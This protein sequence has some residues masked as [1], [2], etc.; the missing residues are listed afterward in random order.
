[1]LFVEEK[2][3]TN[4]TKQ[5]KKKPD[6]TKTKPITHIQRAI[7]KSETNCTDCEM[8]G[9]DSRSYKNRLLD[10]EVLNTITTK[11]FVEKEN[12]P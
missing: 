6:K 11:V 8:A 2:N 1:M 7:R 9:W 5:N 4:K 3:K 12:G 10:L